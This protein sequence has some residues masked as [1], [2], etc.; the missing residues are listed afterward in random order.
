M[1][2]T[3]TRREFFEAASAVLAEEGVGGLSIVA[4]CARLGVTRG[5]FY[6]HF[7]S[8]AEFKGAYLDH[9]ENVVSQERLDIVDRE[10]DFEARSE[11]S[12]RLAQSA[13]FRTE[14]ALRAWS[15]SDPA[16]RDMLRRIDERLLEVVRGSLLRAGASSRQSTVYAHMAVSIYTGLGAREQ[17]P[18]P[19]LIREMYDE[20]KWAALQRVA[21]N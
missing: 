7:D 4:L 12:I 15:V 18:D 10:L 5:S 17:A 20:L 19:E 21:A 11:L 8:L 14:R 13:E 2:R 16:V 3:L 9:W 1:T 6:H